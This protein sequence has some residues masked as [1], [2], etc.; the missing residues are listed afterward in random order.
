MGSTQASATGIRIPR[1]REGDQ[2]I[3]GIPT[4]RSARDLA[5]QPD[6]LGN[7]RRWGPGRDSRSSSRERSDTDQR[8]KERFVW[9]NRTRADHIRNNSAYPRGC[10]RGSVGTTTGHKAWNRVLHEEKARGTGECEVHVSGPSDLASF[11]QRSGI[12]RGCI[13]FWIG[14]RSPSPDLDRRIYVF[15]KPPEGHRDQPHH[16]Y[17]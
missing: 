3:C 5:G 16:C 4:F 1:T 8:S 9:F 13:H 14:S 11:K 2:G 6:R 17:Q 12:D 15:T 10:A 7:L